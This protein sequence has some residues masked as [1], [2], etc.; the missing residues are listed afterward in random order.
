ND[1]GDSTFINQSS[2]GSPLVADC[3]RLHDNI[4]GDGTWTVWTSQRTIATYGTCA[5]GVSPRYIP[6]EIGNGDVRDLI[7]DSIARFQWFDKVGAKGVM[8]CERP[9]GDWTEV[10]WGIYH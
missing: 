1:C 6:A 10:E 5:F 9:F 3:W 7:R 4:A 2:G 8:Q